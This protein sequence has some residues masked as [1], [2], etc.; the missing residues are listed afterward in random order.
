LPQKRKIALTK[1]NSWRIRDRK[2]RRGE[3]RTLGTQQ[4]SLEPLEPLQLLF[5]FLPHLGKRRSIREE[6]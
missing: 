4:N 1:E 2:K 5:C 6:P 3:F